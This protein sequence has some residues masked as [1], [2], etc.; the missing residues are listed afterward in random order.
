[1]PPIQKITL[2]VFGL[3]Q[4]PSFSFLKNP[5]QLLNTESGDSANPKKI[6]AIL[7]WVSTAAVSGHPL[8]DFNLTNRKYRHQVYQL[9]I[10]GPTSNS[11]R[12]F[13]QFRKIYAYYIV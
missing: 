1:M 8:I 7:I 12:Q 3:I 6:M 2:R 13:I 11:R 5:F 4:Y 9:P 10:A